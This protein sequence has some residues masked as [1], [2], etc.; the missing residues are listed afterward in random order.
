MTTDKQGFTNDCI[1]RIR[2]TERQLEQKRSAEAIASGKDRSA[3]LEN[4]QKRYENGEYLRAAEMSSE[5][6][7][8]MIDGLINNGAAD[9]S[10]QRRSILERLSE[11]KGAVEYNPNHSPPAPQNKSIEYYEDDI[12]RVRK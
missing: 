5:Q 3:H 8:N 4:W 1:S 9:D 10:V 7:Y 2:E 12:Q 11:K 6:N